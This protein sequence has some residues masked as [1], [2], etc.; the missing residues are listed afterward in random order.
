MNF[1][2]LQERVRSELKRRIERGTLSV[3]LLARQTGLGQ[4]HISNFLHMRRQL[5]LRSLDKILAAQQMAVEDL[6][7]ERRGIGDER[8]GEMARIPL[9]AHSVAIFEPYIN[10]TSVQ[11]MLPFPAE[12]VMGLEQRCGNRRLQWDR[13]VGV[14]I[15]AD[16]ARGMEPVVLPDAVVVV[17]RHYTSFRPY[18]EGVATL[19]AARSGIE[20]ARLLVRYAQF[21]AGRAVLR[22]FQGQMKA[23]ML[24]PGAGEGESDLLVGRVV[25][26]I[27]VV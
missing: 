19:Y 7:P 27:N 15:T 16:E 5:S 26:V 21:Q 17:D 22:A 14:R 6:Q 9:V 1:S 25:A 11:E 20:G 10:P 18:R 24:Q 2:Q 4:P 13:Y 3:S 8:R 23:E 12:V